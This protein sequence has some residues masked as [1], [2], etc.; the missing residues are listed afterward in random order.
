MLQI[1]QNTKPKAQN[2]EANRT[3]LIG[4]IRLHETAQLELER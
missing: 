2:L 1:Q 3:D 4:V